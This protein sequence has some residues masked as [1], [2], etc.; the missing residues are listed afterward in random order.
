MVFGLAALFGLSLLIPATPNQKALGGAK[1]YLIGKP[2]RFDERD[3]VFARFRSLVPGSEHYKTYYSQL[4][5]EKEELDAKR[6]E[7]GFLGK[8]GSIDS[9]YLP[10]VAMMKASFDIPPYLGLY[11]YNDPDTETPSA[12]LTPEKAA[13]IVKN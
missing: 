7:R 6:R 13:D 3:T 10:N 2:V 1:G 4:H 11:A 9:G 8:P 5:P 12:D